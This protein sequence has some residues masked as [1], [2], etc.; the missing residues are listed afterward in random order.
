MKMRSFA[1]FTILG[2]LL[3]LAPITGIQAAE[4]VVLSSVAVKT[5]MEEVGP[6]FEQTT[7]YKLVL[8]STLRSLP[9]QG[10]TI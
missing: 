8:R 5:V 7:K 4:I 3:L 1:I 9:L 6:Q 10:S 2:M